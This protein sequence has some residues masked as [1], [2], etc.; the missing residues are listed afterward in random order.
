MVEIILKVMKW[1][2]I[3]V[4]VFDCVYNYIDIDNYMFR[5]GVIFV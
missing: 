4:L 2:K 1:D 3:V 5:K